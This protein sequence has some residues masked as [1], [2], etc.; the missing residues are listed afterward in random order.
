MEESSEHYQT[1]SFVKDESSTPADNE[2]L[3]SVKDEKDDNTKE[4]IFLTK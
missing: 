1:S 4:P 3:M 2:Q